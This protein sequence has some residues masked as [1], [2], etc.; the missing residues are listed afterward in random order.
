MG[1]NYETFVR[2]V[3]NNTSTANNIDSDCIVQIDIMNVF[4]AGRCLIF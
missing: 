3:I 4:Q 2:S 1:I